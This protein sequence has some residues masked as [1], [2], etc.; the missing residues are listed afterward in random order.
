M[1]DENI[2]QEFKT[3]N[4]DKTRNYL[5]KEINQL[6]NAFSFLLFLV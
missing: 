5:I 3:Q 6:V 4:I 2:N 1:S